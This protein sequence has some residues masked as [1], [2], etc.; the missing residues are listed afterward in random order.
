MTTFKNLL[1]LSF[2]VMM[3]ILST[4]SCAKHAVE[5]DIIIESKSVLVGV[6]RWDAWY[7]MEN[8]ISSTTTPP[9]V[10]E[11]TLSPEK[12]HFRAPFF[13]KIES[14]KVLLPV[15]SQ[16]LIDQEILLARNAGIDYFAYCWYKDDGSGL[17]EARKYH[18]KSSYRKDVKMCAVIENGHFSADKEIDGLIAAFGQDNYQTVLGGRPLVY[19]FSA[20]SITATTISKIKSKAKANNIHD[21]YFVMMGFN[22]PS[23]DAKNTGCEGI[24]KYTSGGSNG[25]AFSTNAGYE[26]ASWNAFKNT[27]MQVIPIVTSGWD[28]RPRI[29]RTDIGWWGTATYCS[30]CWIQQATAQ[31]VANQVDAALI[32]VKENKTSCNAN[33]ILI[34]AWCE[35]DEGGWI[36]PTINDYHNGVLIPERLNAIAEIIKKHK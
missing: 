27:G 23:A 2:I 12:Y 8:S 9:A 25:A 32:W 28:P 14:G 35:N 3:T 33:S 18:N 11:Q 19:F 6:I 10:V 20:S 29:E 13:A 16:A 34:Y 26:R 31:E 17:A 4:A 36:A 21:P 7:K 24:S 5:S 1:Q 22:N 15:I 30:D